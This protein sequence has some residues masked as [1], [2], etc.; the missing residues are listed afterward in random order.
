MFER[1]KSR[2]AE[3]DI[4]PMTGEDCLPVSKLH[5]QRFARGWSDGEFHALLSQE[6]VLGFSAH[7]SG[8]LP[9]RNLAGFV[10]AREVAGEAEILSIAVDSKWSGCG[11]GWRLMQTAIKE[12]RYRGG[13]S[14]FLEVDE[15]N[16]AAIALYRK[17]RFAKIAER[18]GYY[19]NAEGQKSTALVM[20]LD[21]V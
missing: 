19:Q 17:L 10:L 3:F 12:I 8:L 21:L 16:A 5:G 11:L 4:S 2:N 15:G 7:R 14:V 20:R 6:T 13:E 18:K 1:L 9:G